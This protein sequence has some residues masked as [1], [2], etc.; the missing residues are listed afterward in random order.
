M[1]SNLTGVPGW[2][3]VRQSEI[4][5][6]ASNLGPAAE[7][8]AGL[9]SGVDC[10]LFWNSCASE[11]PAM[12]RFALRYILGTVQMLRGVSYS[13]ILFTVTQLGEKSLKQLLFL[14]FNRFIFF[15]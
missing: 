1:S 6:Y 14:Y 13:T 12:S 4:F 2:S 10:L 9:S 7:K 15:D 3:D 5:R 8:K 11:L